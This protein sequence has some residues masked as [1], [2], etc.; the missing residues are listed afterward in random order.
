MPAHKEH[1][2]RKKDKQDD[3]QIENSHHQYGVPD[4]WF[5]CTVKSPRVGLHTSAAICLISLMNT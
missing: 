4:H 1:I 5:W 2:A 3:D